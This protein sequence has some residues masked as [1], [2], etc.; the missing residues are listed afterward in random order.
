MQTTELQECGNVDVV[1]G[2]EGVATSGSFITTASA[3]Q[4]ASFEDPST[5][6]FSARSEV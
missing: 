5:K 4:L 2:E 3:G 1:E 6:I